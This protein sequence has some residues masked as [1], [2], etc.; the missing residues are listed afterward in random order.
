M[1]RESI[2]LIWDRIGDYH[3][4][5]VNACEEILEQ[6]VF[7]ADLAGADALYKWNSISNTTHTVLSTKAAEKSDVINRF[8]AFRK[9]VK[10]HSITAVA[11]PYGRTEYHVFLLYARLKGIH[12]IIFSESWY[13][14]GRVKD[15]FKSI[16]LKIL[17][18]YFFVSGKRA[19]DHFTKNYSIHPLRIVSGY[20]VVDNTHFNASVNDP[21]LKADKKNIVCVARYSPEKNLNVLIRCFVSS[22]LSKRYTLL[23][24]GDGPL[25]AE[26]NQL[27]E[28]L[29]VTDRVKLTG[30]VS[31]SELPKIYASSSC[32]VLPSKFEP[33][34][35]VV[36]EAL[37]A[38]LP[39]I[40]SDTCG[41]CPELLEV[42][43][44]GFSF[45]PNNAASLI[46][47]LNKF[48]RLGAEEIHQFG[49]HSKELVD[50]LTPQTW[51]RTIK[52][53]FM[54]YEL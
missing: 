10:E 47:A 48:S 36:N 42:D 16:L 40:L 50:R 11:M 51:A 9:I 24:V 25:R 37:A 2:L 6:D 13:S 46:T 39:V 18:Q 29:A 20:S 7:T 52:Q 14:R 53:I 12:T 8:R 28:S 31:Y 30:W 41:C 4:A 1:K 26:L 17:G 5:R 45:D 15:F 38:G 23:L 33:W 43:K 27:I 54:N 32:F 44:N 49:V 22:D 3:Y 35:L 34:G 21:V 19:F